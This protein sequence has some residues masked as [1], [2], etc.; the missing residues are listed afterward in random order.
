MEFRL[1]KYL[2]VICKILGLF[3]NPFTADNKYSLLSRGNLLQ[4]FMMQLYHK[5]KILFQFF[6]AF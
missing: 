4:H 2:C 1:K 5:S 3:V 6:S